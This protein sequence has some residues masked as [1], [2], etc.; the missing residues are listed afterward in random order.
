MTK[1]R[2]TPV[3]LPQ[4]ASRKASIIDTQT[5]MGIMY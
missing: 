4:G 1:D 3:N 5:L 2:L